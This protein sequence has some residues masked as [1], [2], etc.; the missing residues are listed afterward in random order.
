MSTF[1]TSDIKEHGPN[2]K[3][4]ENVLCLDVLNDFYI[5]IPV[6]LYI[7]IK[8]NH[9]FSFLLSLISEQIYNLNFL[10]NFSSTNYNI[11]SIFQHKCSSDS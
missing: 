4:L 3:S 9:V 6:L 5:L 10:K 1:S 8:Y 7:T 2:I 11:S